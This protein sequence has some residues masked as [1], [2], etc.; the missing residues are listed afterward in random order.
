MNGRTAKKTRASKPEEAASPA[1]ALTGM[2]G[3][4]SGDLRDSAGADGVPR[5]DEPG[6]RNV[7]V[8]GRDRHSDGWGAVRASHHHARD[9]VL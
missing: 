5:H 8:L 9:A 2:G 7:A 1:H 3:Q 6:V 4:G